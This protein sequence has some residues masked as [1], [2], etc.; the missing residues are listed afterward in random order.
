VPASQPTGSTVGG[1]DTHS[2]L[3]HR[4]L[5]PIERRHAECRSIQTCHTSHC[6]ELFA[7]GYD[8]RV[9][10]ATA[11]G[12]TP[13]LSGRLIEAFHHGIDTS[14]PDAAQRTV[15]VKGQPTKRTGRVERYQT[16]LLGRPLQPKCYS[17][18]TDDPK[19]ADRPSNDP[20]S[21][22][23]RTRPTTETTT[24]FGTGW[25]VPTSRQSTSHKYVLGKKPTHPN[26]LGGSMYRRYLFF[27]VNVK[28]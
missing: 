14:T 17:V 28:V 25:N 20:R 23:N 1:C 10:Q 16:V 9:W 7:R 21:K 19:K 27:F 6:K 24:T 11:A 15:T 13:L 18:E 12:K 5:P 26:Q 22:F 3:A 8:S 2:G 4:K